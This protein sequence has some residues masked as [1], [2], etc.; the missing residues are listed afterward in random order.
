MSFA[1]NKKQ[2]LNIL[3]ASSA[4]I[5]LQGCAAALVPLAA[6]GLVGTAAETDPEDESESVDQTVEAIEANTG[7][8]RVARSDAV[9]QEQMPVPRRAGPSEQVPRLA[10]EREAPPP[11]PFPPPPPEPESTPE[12]MPVQEIEPQPEEAA[13]PVM[14]SELA[15]T[16]RPAREPEP[17][18]PVVVQTLPE[19]ADEPEAVPEAAPPESA[20]TTETRVI[21]IARSQ[22]VDEQPSSISAADAVAAI[23]SSGAAEAAAPSAPAA[24]EVPIV[25]AVSPNAITTLI[26]YTNQQRFEPAGSRSSAILADRITLEP[27]RAPCLGVRPTIL[28]DLDPD[29]GVLS[30]ANASR[31]PSGLAGGL[32]Q[33]RE[34]G[35]DVAWI[36]SNPASAANAI[37]ETLRETGLDPYGRDQLLLVR[38]SD[39]RKQTLR[40]GLAESTCIVAIAGDTRS[41]FDEL[42]D[43]LLNPEDAASL[44]PLFGDGWFIIPQPLLSEGSE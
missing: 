44:E 13:T 16:M 5:L 30:P 29:G 42:Y 3:M 12:P 26:S 14:D 23:A 34:D 9:A 19:Q 32:E 4:A 24:P 43:Y 8:V 20:A 1:M 10:P 36:S 39:D 21:R 40:D 38:N 2:T 22:M 6:G 15:E 27:D 33:L 7:V 28:I 11:E 31:P 35:V 25:R 41:D 17:P 18:A 37:R